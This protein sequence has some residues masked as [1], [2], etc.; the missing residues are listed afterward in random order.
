MWV[1]FG[2]D[3]AQGWLIVETWCWQSEPWDAFLRHSWISL[4]SNLDAGIGEEVLFRG[5]LLTGLCRAWGKRLGLMITASIVAAFHL[6]VTAANQTHWITF[7]LLLSLPGL[8]FG[9]AYLRAGSLWLPIGIHFTWDPAYDLYNLAGGLH[10][11]V[12]GAATRQVGPSWFVGTEFGI[13]TGLASVLV[14]GIIRLGV[15]KWTLSWRT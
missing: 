2:I 10:P 9:D 6:M 12:F 11:G 5:F 14:T 1:I 13:E 7:T 8:V 15:W 3:V 4:L